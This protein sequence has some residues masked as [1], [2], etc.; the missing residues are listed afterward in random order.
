MNIFLAK[1]YIFKYTNIYNLKEPQNKKG[2]DI[3]Q[4]CTQKVIICT[5][6][7]FTNNQSTKQ[8]INAVL[9]KET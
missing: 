9:P 3:N 8:N 4:Q 2:K 5:Q 6:V 1:R 7:I